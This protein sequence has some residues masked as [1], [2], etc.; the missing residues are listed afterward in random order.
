M[1]RL[2]KE[3]ILKEF[4][5][6]ETKVIPSETT[7]TSSISQNLTFPEQDYMTELYHIYSGQSLVPKTQGYMT[8]CEPTESQREKHSILTTRTY[9]LKESPEARV[10]SDPES[11]DSLNLWNPTSLNLTDL[12]KSMTIQILIKYKLLDEEIFH[13]LEMGL[14][15]IDKV[16]ASLAPYVGKPTAIAGVYVESSKKKASFLEAAEKGFLAKMHAVEFLQTQAATGSLTDLTT[17]QIYSLSEALERGIFDSSLK[18]KLT[19]AEKAFYGYMHAG[20]RLSVFQAMEESILERYKGKKILE[21]QIATGGVINPEGGF[22]MPPSVAIDH[23]FLNKE[24]LQILYDPVRNPKGFHNPYTGQKAYY[25]EILK[26][27]LYDI[28]GGVLLL[29]IGDR[30]LTNSSPTSS[31]RVSVVS[32]SR[33]TEMSAHEAFKKKH[34]DKQT[35]L[36]LSKQESEWHETSVE[37]GSGG[38]RHILN[39][40][41]NGRKLCLESAVSQRFLEASELEQYR[42]GLLSIY[43]IADIIFSRMVV[44]EDVNSPIAGLWDLAQ[45]KRLSIFQGFQQGFTDGTTALRLLEAQACTGGICDPFSGEKLTVNDAFS[46]GLLNEKFVQKLQQFEQV[47]NGITHPKT[48]KSVSITQAIQENLLPKDV[49]TRCIE[50]QLLTG[51][52]INPDTHDRVSLEEVLQRGLVD[53]ATA[54]AVKDEK[55]HI[56]NITCPKTKRRLTFKEAL[57]RSVYDC[58]TGLRLLE[59]DKDQGFGVLSSLH[60][61]KLK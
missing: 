47:F 52:L 12:Q 57:N 13:K 9:Y 18:D 32:S 29:P 15:T 4:E 58:H 53:K 21:V 61:R 2:Q 5:P 36:F 54:S 6:D 28:D 17:G 20:K 40:V 33:G 37:N 48:A 46:E 44:V 16:Q 34:I 43:E 24:T 59:A 41:K 55:S 30:H 49:G 45:K 35:Y 11:R 23:G 22:R 10:K 7:L 42:N 3:D 27:C 14:T 8:P 56:K 1:T 38:L 25:C 39:D 60:H 50:F 31:H 19:E 26:A 51:G